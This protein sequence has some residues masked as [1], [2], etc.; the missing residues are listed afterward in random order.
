MD[1]RTGA[2]KTYY[3]APG[4]VADGRWYLARHGNLLGLRV[5]SYVY[6]NVKNRRTERHRIPIDGLGQ[7]V[8]WLRS[9]PLQMA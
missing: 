9:A 4:N 3:S 1:L 7:E 2:K 8:L 6:V 5:Q